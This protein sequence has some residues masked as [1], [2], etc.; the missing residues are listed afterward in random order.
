MLADTCSD[1]FAT[2]TNSI[3]VDIADDKSSHKIKAAE[4]FDTEAPSIANSD[5]TK[6]PLPTLVNQPD[7]ETT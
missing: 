2:N 3:E 1:A 5:I 4:I 7:G 6:K